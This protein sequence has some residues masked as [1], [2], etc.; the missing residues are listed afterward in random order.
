MSIDSELSIMDHQHGKARCLDH[1][2]MITVQ[3][4][5][6]DNVVQRGCSE[7]EYKPCFVEITNALSRETHIGHMHLLVRW[8]SIG[9]LLHY[10]TYLGPPC[11]Y[12]Y[13]L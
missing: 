8:P 7:L 2:Q 13:P 11:A 6:N 3:E 4:K 9:C 10:S 1:L 5:L 12:R